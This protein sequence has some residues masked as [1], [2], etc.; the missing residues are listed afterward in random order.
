MID[1]QKLLENLRRTLEKEKNLFRDAMSDY[2][3]G[4]SRG[5]QC[6]LQE[7]IKL[8]ENDTFRVVIEQ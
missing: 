5:V 2:D 7:L 4:F 6:E 1:K 8:I 3:R